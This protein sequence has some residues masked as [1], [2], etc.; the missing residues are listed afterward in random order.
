M[1]SLKAFLA[2]LSPLVGT[3]TG[4]LYER[5]RSL[6]NLGILSAKAGRG[7]GSGVPLSIRNVAKLVIAYAGVNSLSEV[8]RVAD[9]FSAASYNPDDVCP[10]TGQREFL[11]VLTF[12]FGKPELAERID[13]IEIDIDIH[14]G[15]ILMTYL[16][17]RR[18]IT[19]YQFFFGEED[20]RTVGTPIMGVTKR[21]IIYYHA[22]AGISNA[23]IGLK[24][25]S[26]LAD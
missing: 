16:T 23:L 1:I 8:D 24:F 3:T 13:K 5:Q 26:A 15:S 7:P 12:L 19:A 20:R 21:A 4:V 22:I 17:P 25:A 2:V 14:G 6:V 18:K 10:L 11:D 9:I